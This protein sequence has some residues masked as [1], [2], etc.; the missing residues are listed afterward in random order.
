MQVLSCEIRSEEEFLDVRR[1]FRILVRYVVREPISGAIVQATIHS[2]DGSPIISTE[3]TD[4]NVEL[5]NKREPGH[6]VTEVLV[7]GDWL[8]PGEYVLRL[9]LGVV[10]KSIYDD[11][12]VIAFELLETGSAR[13]R[14]H[15]NAYI[16]PYLKWTYKLI[17]Y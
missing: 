13:L 11:I 16:L 1:G 3:D 7:P 5:L 6:Y 15:K 14:A 2:L 12:E 4:M 9:H 8:G 10:F 17:D